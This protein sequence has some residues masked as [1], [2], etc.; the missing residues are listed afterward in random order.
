MAHSS[1]TSCLRG[2][3]LSGTPSPNPP[4]R[5]PP[6]LVATNPAAALDR[7]PSCHATALF[8]CAPAARSR[9]IPSCAAVWSPHA[10]APMR[11]PPGANSPF[12]CRHVVASRR[13]RLSLA[14]LLMHGC[15]AEAKPLG[16]KGSAAR[17]AAPTGVTA[18]QAVD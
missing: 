18:T 16:A 15:D 5:A 13:C 4:C 12:L 11:L 9:C 2:S 6:A 14:A 3:R 8:T 17:L 1:A 7:L 10:A